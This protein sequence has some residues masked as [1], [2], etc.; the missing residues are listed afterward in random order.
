MGMELSIKDLIGKTLTRVENIENAEIVF[1]VDDG[2]KFKLYHNQD[3]CE[4]VTVNDIAGDPNDLVGSPITKAEESTSDKNPP[5]VSMEL[6]DYPLVR[7]IERLLLGDGGFCGG[8]MTPSTLI[9]THGDRYA[10]N[11][12]AMDGTLDAVV[13]ILDLLLEEETLTPAQ[14][15]KE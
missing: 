1:T 3:C 10:D 6:C 7:R 15:G 2:S 9:L 14:A 4:T 5:G 13:E 8:P 11:Y 12:L